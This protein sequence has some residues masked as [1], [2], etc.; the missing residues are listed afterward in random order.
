LLQKQNRKI[1]DSL[2]IPFN[3]FFISFK[4]LGKFL[5][6]SFFNS[7]S[8]ENI[9]QLNFQPLFLKISYIFILKSLFKIKKKMKN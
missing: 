8:N 4:S 6:T 3:I 2:S 7:F 9:F 5:K 1:L